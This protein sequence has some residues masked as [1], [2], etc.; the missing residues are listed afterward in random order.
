VTKSKQKPISWKMQDLG[1]K[2]FQEFRNISGPTNNLTPLQL[3]EH[4]FEEATLSL[5]QNYSN[6]YAA[7]KNE[8]GDINMDE[9][10]CSIRV[11]ILSGYVVCI[12]FKQQTCNICNLM[13][14]FLS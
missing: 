9:I 10:R 8:V 11:L 7:Q 13:R 6:M 4:F 14:T 2:N 3:F 5:I 12:R 1:P